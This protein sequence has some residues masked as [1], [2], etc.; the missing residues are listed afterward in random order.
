M[1]ERQ[2]PSAEA[3]HRA[4]HRERTDAAEPG[5]GSVSVTGPLALESDGGATQRGDEQA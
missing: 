1:P 5:A 4:E 3:G 2:K